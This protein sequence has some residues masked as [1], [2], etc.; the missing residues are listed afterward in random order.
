MN[1]LAVTEPVG[2][3]SHRRLNLVF[4]FS[5]LGQQFPTGINRKTNKTN[6]NIRNEN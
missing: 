5:G 2:F 3:R 4:S 6:D 1:N